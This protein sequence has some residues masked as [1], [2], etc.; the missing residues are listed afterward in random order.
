M[1]KYF[2]IGLLLFFPLFAFAENKISMVTYFPVPYVAYSKLSIHNLLDIGVGRKCEMT[3]GSAGSSHAGLRP[4]MATDAYLKQGRLNL[5]KAAAITSTSVLMGSGQG[6]AT[7]DFNRNL[8][9]GTLNNGYTLQANQMNLDTLK[10]FPDRVNNSF[11]SCAD[12]GVAGA[13]KISWQKLTMKDKEETFLVCGNPK[14]LETVPE[15]HTCGPL[16]AELIS[17]T[18]KQLIFD[19]GRQYWGDLGDSLEMASAIG[20]GDCSSGAFGNVSY[21]GSASCDGGSG[22]I[23]Y[24]SDLTCDNDNVIHGKTTFSCVQCVREDIWQ[25]IIKMTCEYRENNKTWECPIGKA[26]GNRYNTCI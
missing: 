7:L 8:R 14:Q 11:P 22:D 23:R 10:L 26:C 21:S 24:L 17:Q 20:P 4:L 5:L 15:T 16:G 25:H 3:L 1:K 2:T 18:Y 19:M 9:I 12:T 13:P 6:N